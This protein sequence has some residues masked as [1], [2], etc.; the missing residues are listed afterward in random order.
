MLIRYIQIVVFLFALTVGCFLLWQPQ[1][2]I[3]IQIAFYRLINWNIQPLS[4]KRE[5][6]TTC[7]MGVCVLILALV[8]I[9]YVINKQ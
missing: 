7:I 4:M 5:I 9:G 1:R 8:A 6:I 2:A 3:A